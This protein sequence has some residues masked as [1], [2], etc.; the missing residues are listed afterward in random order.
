M[1]FDLDA[2]SVLA[3]FGGY[4]AIAATIVLC[5]TIVGA[6]NVLNPSVP[7]MVAGIIAAFAGGA[8]STRLSDGCDP[9]AS[10]W[11]AGLLASI[12]IAMLVTSPS[13]KEPV[14]DKP[15]QT[16]PFWSRVATI[17]VGAVVTPLGGIAMASC[18]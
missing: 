8:A 11:L 15:A 9:V 1:G 5:D 13:D 16:E 7:M 6:S 14:K 3:I 12:G 17:V 4:A 10:Y 18:C 2:T